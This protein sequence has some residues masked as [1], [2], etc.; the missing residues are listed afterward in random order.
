M[1]NTRESLA[2]RSLG[3]SP[4]VWGVWFTDDPN[5]VWGKQYL[6]EIAAAG[7]VYNLIGGVEQIVD[8]LVEQLFA[9][10]EQ[11][12]LESVPIDSPAPEFEAYVE[13]TW[14]YLA[15]REEPLRAAQ[16]AVFQR[17]LAI[18]ASKPVMRVATRSVGHLAGA[19]RALQ[20]AGRLSTDAEHAA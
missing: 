6:D 20:R 18:G 9:G 19:V 16:R 10:M 15:A 2:R 7:Y 12:M 14:R 4:D 1:T 3:T 17:A 8:R 5:Q 11:A 13:S